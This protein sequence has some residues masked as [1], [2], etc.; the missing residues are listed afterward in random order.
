M[1]IIHKPKC[2]DYDMATFRNLN[3]S[4]LQW[5]DH[6]HKNSLYFKIIAVFE[7][8]NEIEKF[9]IGKKTINTYKQNPVL[10]PYYIR[11]EMDRI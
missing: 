6:F 10:N 1:L 2:E 7:A 4:H 5:K 9:S 8:G 3:E 11:S